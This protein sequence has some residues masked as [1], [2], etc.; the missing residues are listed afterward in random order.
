MCRNHQ[1]KSRQWQHWPIHCIVIF[2]CA[3]D[4][5]ARENTSRISLRTLFGSVAIYTK[6]S[7]PC[8]ER[9]ELKHKDIEAVTYPNSS[10]ILIC[11]IYRPPN[12]LVER[13]GHFEDMCDKAYSE[14]KQMIIIVD[15]NLDFLKKTSNSIWMV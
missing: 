9:K 11:A 3:Y 7:V 4:I 6:D 15:I 5:I 14:D 1:L 10:P 12:S 8:E 2:M 13:Y